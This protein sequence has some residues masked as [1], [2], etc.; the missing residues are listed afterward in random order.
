MK[1]PI[2]KILN[3]RTGQTLFNFFEWLREKGYPTGQSNR[4]ADTF[5]IPDDEFEKR[6]EEFCKEMEGEEVWG[7]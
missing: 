7:K 2:E 6:W 3:W 1:P 5:H 4:M